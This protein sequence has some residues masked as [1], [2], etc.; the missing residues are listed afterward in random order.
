MERCS[1]DD[2]RLF[3]AVARRRSFVRAAAEVRTPPSTLSRRLAALEDA[4]GARLL[5]RTSRR[6]ALTRE[7]EALL[8]RAAPLLD[9]LALATEATAGGAEVPRG[10]VRVT[11]PMVTGSEWVGPT[12]ARLT[13]QHAELRVELRL[14]NDVEDLVDA[15]IDVAVRAG[16]LAP[17]RFVATRLRAV[18]Y[19]LFASP[20]LVERHLSGATRVTIEE[21]AELPAIFTRGSLGWRLQTANGRARDVAP[22]PRF[23][24]NDPRVA[25]AAAIDG[26]G[27]MLA[28]DEMAARY[29]PALVRLKCVGH[30]VAPRSL[31]VVTPARA[32]MPLRTRVVVD[33]LVAA[34]RPS[35]ARV[36]PGA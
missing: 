18:T 29:G 22:P 19:S 24:V 32:S 4:L 33:A 14:T 20:S 9:E 30:T 12:L 23:V 1:L 34:G 21:L 17:S 35:R 5:E 7:G 26:T 3:T 31:F 28:P 15:R 2:L 25:L 11:A 36:R 13:R 8:A 6:V 16:P 10:T 27:V